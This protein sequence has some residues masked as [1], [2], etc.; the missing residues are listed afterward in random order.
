MKRTRLIF[1]GTGDAF[2]SGGRHLSSYL[3][4]HPEGE[5][6]LDCGPTIL[7]SL[8]RH[9]LS[10]EAIDA[11]LLTHFHGDHIAGLPFL[12]LHYINIEPRSRLLKIVGPP[13]VERRVMEIFRAMYADTAAEPLPFALEFVEMKPGERRIFGGAEIDAFRTVHQEDPP[14]LGF[15]IRAGDRKII[16]VGDS[17]WSEDLIKHTQGADLF[18]CECSFFETRYETHLD[19][20]RIAENA[21][22]F[23]AKRII[24][25]HLGQEV[26]DRQEEVAL[27]M[28][29]DGLVIDL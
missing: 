26:L 16:Y 10:A 27:E 7:A 24:L 2:A 21:G 4:Q 18:L 14:S 8:N 28:A 17:G 12:F 11:I 5:L 3:L 20:P 13:E 23:G 1:L 15:K 6:L 25:T 9:G 29:Q 19:Y 22:R